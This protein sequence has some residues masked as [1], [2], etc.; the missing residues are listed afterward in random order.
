MSYTTDPVTGQTLTKTCNQCGI[1][2]PATKEFFYPR[3]DG[4]G[5]GWSS[6]CKV[7]DKIRRDTGIRPTGKISKP[8]ERDPENGLRRCTGCLLWLPATQEYFAIGTGS[9]DGCV[10]KCKSCSHSIQKERYDNDLEFNRKRREYSLSYHYAHQDE[11]E[12]RYRRWVQHLKQAHNINEETYFDRLDFQGWMCATPGCGTP[13][14][15]ENRLFVDHD[16]DH[17][18]TRESCGKCIRGL[19]CPP[20]NSAMGLVGDNPIVLLGLAEYLLAWESEKLTIAS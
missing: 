8:A 6:P 13:H 9:P 16:H 11:Y 15:P 4:R 18:P 19:I 1:E 12:Y 17:C 7:C 3:S 2:K 20:C 14:T 10:A 5:G